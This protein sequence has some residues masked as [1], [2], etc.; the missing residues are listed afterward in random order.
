MGPVI[1]GVGTKVG[2]AG[3]PGRLGYPDLCPD[4]VIEGIIHL[5]LSLLEVAEAL[6]PACCFSWKYIHDTYRPQGK[7]Q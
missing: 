3:N 5:I 2:E 1:V 7:L 4:G 6:L